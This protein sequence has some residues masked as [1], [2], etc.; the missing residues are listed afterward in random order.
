[1]LDTNER[2]IL[3]EFAQQKKGRREALRAA[4]LLMIDEGNDDKTVAIRLGVSRES[5]IKWKEKWRVERLGLLRDKRRPGRPPRF[6]DK[7]MGQ[8][9]AL[10]HEHDH[11]LVKVQFYFEANHGKKISLTTLRRFQRSGKLSSHL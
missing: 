3:R 8:I 4:A 11:D 6:S 5:I 9:A 7:D 1:M 10:F 2:V